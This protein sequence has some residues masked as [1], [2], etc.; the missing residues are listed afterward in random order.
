MSSVDGDPLDWTVDEVIEFLCRSAETS[1]SQFAKKRP[2]PDPAFLEVWLRDNIVDGDVLLNEIDGEVLLNDLGLKALGHRSSMLKA[3]R[4]LRERSLQY[5]NCH[6]SDNSLGDRHG[7]SPT[8]KRASEASPTLG[9]PLSGGASPQQRTPRKPSSMC[10]SGSVSRNPIRVGSAELAPSALQPLGSTEKENTESFKRRKNE[11]IDTSDSPSLQQL[12]APGSGTNIRSGEHYVVDQEGKKRR[13]L[14]LAPTNET[15]SASFTPQTTRVSADKVWY[16][17]PNSITPDELFYPLNEDE[18]GESFV[19]ASPRFPTAQSSFVN[20]HLKYFYRQRPVKLNGQSGDSQWG[21]VPYRPSKGRQNCFTLYTSRDG[22]VTVTKENIKEWPQLDDT[23]VIESSPSEDYDVY[24]LIAQKYQSHENYD[25]DPVLPCYGESGSEGEYDEETWE[26]ID[27]EKQEPVA[28]QNKQL[29][30]AEVDSIIKNSITEYEKEWFQKYLHREEPKARRLWDDAKKKRCTNQKIQAY[31]VDIDY[32]EARLKKIQAEIRKGDYATKSELGLQCKSMEQTVFNIQQLR[33]RTSVLEQ[34]TRPPVI[35]RPVKPRRKPQPR[36]VGDDESLGYESLDSESD[37]FIIDDDGDDNDEPQAVTIANTEEP[38]EPIEIPT[39][40]PPSSDDEVIIPPGNKRRSRTE[41]KETTKR[42][43][44]TTPRSSSKVE[45]MPEHIDLTQDSDAARDGVTPARRNSNSSTMEDLTIETPPLNPVESNLQEPPDFPCKTERNSS[46]SPTPESGAQRAIAVCVPTRPRASSTMNWEDIEERKDRG[47]LLTKYIDALSDDERESMASFILRYDV[48]RLRTLVRRGLKSIRADSYTIKRIQ[49][50]RENDLIMRTAAFF[51]SWVISSRH[52]SKGLLSSQVDK[53]IR[54]IDEFP[55]FLSELRSRLAACNNDG[56]ETSDSGTPQRP[57]VQRDSN[58]PHK[59]RKRKVKENQDAKRN[60]KEALGRAALQAKQREALEQKITRMGLSNDDPMRKAVSFGNPVIYLDPHI[61]QHVKPHQLKGVQFLWR[62]LIKDDKHQGCL[63]AHTMGLGKTMQVVSLLDTIAAASCSADDS[64]FKQIPEELR[65]SQTLVLCPSSL[66]ENWYEEF[67]FWSPPESN[68]GPLRKITSGTSV[69]ERLHEAFEWDQGGG[70]LILSYEMFRMLVNNNETKTKPRPLGEDDHRNIKDCLLNGPNIIVADEAHRLK[71]PATGLAAAA[72]QFRSRS[73]IALTGSPLANRLME[74]FFMV[75]WV[76]PSYLGE[77]VGFKANYV[78]PIEE[79]LYIDS[80]AQ[81]RKKSLIKLKVLKTILEPKIDRADITVLEGE[82]PPKVEFVITVPLTE[83]Q[84]AAYDS[85]IE[86]LYDGKGE[87][88]NTQLWNWLK[89]L[90]LCCTHP[91]CFRE[92]LLSQRNDTAKVASE[93]LDTIPG[94]ESM[95]QA[96]LPEELIPQQE[97]LFA[98]VPDMTAL[99]LSYRTLILDQI[100]KLSIQAG[101]KVLIFSHRIAALD[102]MENL[103][104]AANHKYCRLDGKTPMNSRQAATKKFN[105][106]F[107]H[108]VYLISTTAGGLG[109]NIP[110]ANRVVIFDFDWNPILEEQAIGRSYRIGQ[111]K[112]VYVYRF[113]AGGTHE[114]VIYNKTI[115]K[116]QLA[117]RVVD[118]K[119]PVRRACKSPGDYL[120]PVKPV[121]Q[122]DV[123]EYVG[124]DPHVLDQI[125]NNDQGAIR[126]IALTETFQKEENDKLTEEDEKEYQ[127]QLSDEQ[128]RRT[129]PAAYEKVLQERQAQYS[130]ANNSHTQRPSGQA[131]HT[132]PTWTIPNSAHNVGP[133]PLLPDT[134]VNTSVS[135]KP[136]LIPLNAIDMPPEAAM[137]MSHQTMQSVFPVHNGRN[138]MASQTGSLQQTPSVENSSRQSPGTP[139]QTEGTN[140]TPQQPGYTTLKNRILG[141]GETDGSGG[142][143][144]CHQQ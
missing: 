92:K 76:A 91:A 102:Y 122:M 113:L 106:E 118:Q 107:E 125:I 99:D 117:Y 83:V 123:S 34:E 62:E 143:N 54:K 142:S 65:R 67:L 124:K 52:G 114:E 93:D 81:E 26:E 140:G 28:V 71:N 104:Q 144:V 29:T 136:S 16:M 38:T 5:Q 32:Y 111:K 20:K 137:E 110:G 73:R 35:A 112:P 4:Y 138:Q 61:G 121:K 98:T 90:S 89:V 31:R 94:D 53:A 96:Y 8:P 23:E 108:Q 42:S 129:D 2:R 115:F 1:W 59:K 66:V 77:S 69:D 68:I 105:T 46:F 40:F 85:Y 36:N 51:I 9:K 25:E 95:T 19:I 27:E 74:Y 130:K 60:Q 84:K 49:D 18:D 50:K 78:E 82:L 63:L 44:K 13:K 64:V 22:D 58:T 24:S 132:R 100:V 133:P 7:V 134:S 21:L 57:N 30:S 37:R 86:S 131:M 119:S 103:L 87:V 56:Q 79:G 48:G 55:A 14:E 72:K 126:R 3:I 70:I 33:W 120:F 128:L 12:A 45:S 75:D 101:D 6:A 11:T 135:V 116:T 10:T 141:P 15:Q 109:L 43:K 88:S 47:M 17:G 97:Q 127:T 80:T 39:T 41:N 139:V